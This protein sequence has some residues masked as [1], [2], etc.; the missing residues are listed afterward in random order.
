MIKMTHKT[1]FEHGILIPRNAYRAK[2]KRS[3]VDVVVSSGWSRYRSDHMHEIKSHILPFS[4]NRVEKN[5]RRMSAN[6]ARDSKT[7]LCSK[8]I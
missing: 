4:A 2:A 6:G 1:I 5:N 8:L 7:I 3:D